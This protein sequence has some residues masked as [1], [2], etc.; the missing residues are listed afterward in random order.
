M[1]ILNQMTDR[2]VELAHLATIFSYFDD[3]KGLLKEGPLTERRAFIK[4][5]FIRE[6]K[7]TGNGA[8]L[9]HTMPVLPDKLTIRGEN[10]SSPYRT[11]WWAL[12]YNRQ[13]FFHIIQ[14]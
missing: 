6:V 10:E 11:L 3:L 2:R 4:K 13:N 14:S 7:V 5:S 12:Q 1:E 9:G 8:V